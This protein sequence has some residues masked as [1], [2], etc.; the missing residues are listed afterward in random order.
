MKYCNEDFELALKE[1]N[2]KNKI[3]KLVD[4]KI[5]EL[6][7]D[8]LNYNDDSNLTI[9]SEDSLQRTLKVIEKSSF[10]ILT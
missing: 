10:A 7:D 1:Y 3:C 2:V 6:L 4:D 8:E 9:L 5:V